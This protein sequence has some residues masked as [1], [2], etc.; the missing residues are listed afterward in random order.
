MFLCVHVCVCARGLQSFCI[1]CLSS[2][3]CR[4]DFSMMYFLLFELMCS[5]QSGIFELF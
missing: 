2:I 1:F 5:R 4:L 3:Q